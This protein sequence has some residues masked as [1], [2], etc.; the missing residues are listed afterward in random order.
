MRKRAKRLGGLALCAACASAV[1][2]RGAAADAGQAQFHR[3]DAEVAALLAKMT[4]DE[5]IGQMMQPDQKFLRDPADIEKYHLGSLLSGG[6]SGPKDPRAYTF[7]GWRAMVEGYQAHA[8]KTRLGIPLLYGVDAVHGHNNIPGATLFPHNV[9]LGCTRDAALAEKIA[10]ITAE[11]VR[12]TAINWTFAPCVT[13]PQDLRWGRTYEGFSSDPA[14]AGTLGAAQ[15]RGFQTDALDGPLAVVATAKHFVADGGTAYGSATRG[16]RLDQGDARIDEATLRRIHLPAYKAAVDAGVATI[17]P[18]YSSWNGVKCSANKYLLTDVLKQEL[19]FEGFVISDYD[20]IDQISPDYATCVETSLNA[21]I[22]MVMMTGGYPRFAD[23]LRTLVTQGKVPQARVDDAVARILRVKFAAGLMADGWTPTAD[24]ALEKSFGSA[25]HRAVARQAVRESLVLLKNHKKVLPLQK[26]ARIVVAGHGAD[27]V[28]MQCGGWTIDWQGKLGQPVP[29]ATSLL[30]ALKEAAG[31]AGRVTHSPDG[32]DAAG[33]EVA[34][35]VVGEPPYAEGRG[36][37]PRLDL[38]DED[39]RTV[40]AAKDA[41][42]PVVVV[43][44]SGRPLVLGD[45][46]DQADA[47]VAAW[48]PGSEGAGMAD[49]LFGDHPPTG[50]LSLPW[51][52]TADDVARAGTADAGAPLFPVGFGLGYAP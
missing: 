15:V 28:G 34:V 17:M 18:S 5:K 24:R 26:A 23:T 46:L 31:P 42:L 29:G 8:K 25:E 32:A 6:G 38:P 21:G 50:K 33:A 11:E 36:D 9:G 1:A 49:V 3:H 10:R 19:G 44:Y 35:V 7:A 39:R 45:V 20:A 52:R 51:P 43:I 41:G 40:K 16:A 30:A 37:V 14:I 47:V 27:D 4:L 2:A 13:T 48:L 22:D 12:A